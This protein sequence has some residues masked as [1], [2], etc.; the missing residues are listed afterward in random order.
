M[1]WNYPVIDDFAGGFATSIKSM[2]LIGKSPSYIRSQIMR[3]AEQLN[4]FV[5][6]NWG[7]ARLFGSSVNGRNL[8]YAFEPGAADAAQAALLR[9]VAQ[10]VRAAYPQVK[11]AFQ[12]IP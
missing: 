8:I 3:S 1:P 11:I 2:D 4:S 12:W 5:P 10:E 6:R 9:Q 7:N